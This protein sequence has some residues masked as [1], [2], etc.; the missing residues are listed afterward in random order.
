MI[1]LR[2]LTNELKRDEGFSGRVYKC[3]AGKLTIGY[4]HNV[5]DN[6]IPE[7]IAGKLLEDDIVGCVA[8]CERWKWFHALSDTQQR[9]IVNMVFNIGFNGV[10]KFK[11]MI[12]AIENE[13]FDLAA[14]EMID[15]RWYVQVGDRAKRIVSMMRFG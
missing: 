15:S 8:K 3:T 1:D 5:E 14:K 6:P 4:G 13:D 2:L 11:R 7:H 12:A 10:C 9:A